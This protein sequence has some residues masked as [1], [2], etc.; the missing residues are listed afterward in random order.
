MMIVPLPGRDAAGRVATP[1]GRPRG[2]RK[3]RKILD[4]TE[5][6]CRRNQARWFT[7]LRQVAI[8]HEPFALGLLAMPHASRR[9]DGASLSRKPLRLLL[10]ANQ[11]P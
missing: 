2:C 6:A 11:S 1:D 9:P 5:S 4:G 10:N 3:V 7:L 8:Q